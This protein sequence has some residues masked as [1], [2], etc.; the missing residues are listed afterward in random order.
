MI[1][2]LIFLAGVSFAALLVACSKPQSDNSRI[3]FATILP[4]KD[5]VRQVAGDRF[6]VHALV[7]P[8]QSPHSYTPTPDQMAQLSQAAAFFRIG[9]EVEEGLLPKL[10]KSMPSL[11]I[12]DLRKGI[13]LHDMT[14]EHHHDDD[15]GDHDH[16]GHAADEDHGEHHAHE[17]A[18]HEDHGAH[19]NHDHHAHGGKDPHIWLSPPLVKQMAIT[20]KD[21]LVEIDPEG[22]QV[23]GK[24]LLVFHQKLDSLDTYIRTTL[25][26]VKGTELFVFH[27]AFG[28]FADEYGLV[29]KPVETGGKEPSARDLAELVQEARE[30]KPKV[31]FVQPQ[32]SQKS[33]QALAAQIECAVVPINP[34]PENYFAEMLDMCA[35]IHAGL[36]GDE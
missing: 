4:Q 24:N 19:D 31:I 20:I 5:F 13:A 9:V 14:E 10:Q 34:L 7:G 12:I 2:R 22:K 18:S 16:D 33:A 26:P 3:V 15:H 11:R 36:S 32:Y 8:G 1:R 28:Y 25:A 29:Q 17:E 23:Y 35:K 6:V 30:H 27:P 21:A